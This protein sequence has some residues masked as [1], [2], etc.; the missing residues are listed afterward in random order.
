MSQ[1]CSAVGTCGQREVKLSHQPDGR[2]SGGSG[3]EGQ[4]ETGSV[5]GGKEKPSEDAELG[6][7][8]GKGRSGP[9]GQ[10]L[11]TPVGVTEGRAV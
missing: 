4:A 8:I 6:V 7:S 2:L 5:Q 11:L 9:V 1:V 3:L 10:E